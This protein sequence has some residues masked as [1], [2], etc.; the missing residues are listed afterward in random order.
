VGRQVADI[1][2]CRPV[3]RARQQQ[4]VDLTVDLNTEQSLVQEAQ[5][6]AGS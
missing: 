2:Q 4:E 3:L 1:W 6:E 5:G